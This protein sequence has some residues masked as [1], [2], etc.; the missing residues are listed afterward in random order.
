MYNEASDSGGAIYVSE[1]GSLNVR[2]KRASSL[3]LLLLAVSWGTW[4]YIYLGVEGRCLVE[5]SKNETLL[6]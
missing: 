6:V 1:D 3:H 2:T 5:W 4:N